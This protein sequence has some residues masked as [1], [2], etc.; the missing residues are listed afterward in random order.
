[1][2]Q[3]I[4]DRLREERSGIEQYVDQTLKGVENRDLS[5]TEVKAVN[6]AKA[7]IQQIDAQAKPLIEY[8]ESRSAAA[9][10]T[11]LVSKATG[12]RAHDVELRS[13]GEQ[14]VASDVFT[15]YNGRGT[16]SRL[17]IETRALPLS[18]TSMAAALPVSPRYDLTA[19]PPPSPLLDLID[20]IPIS[21]NSVEFI[22]WAKI[23]GGADIVA[24][25]AVKP[26]V[27]WAPTV[28]S[29]TLVTIAAWTSATRQLLEDSSAIRAMI[30]TGLRREITQ[31]EESEAAAALV[32]APLP[33]VTGPSM[34]ESIR[35]GVGT[36][37]AQGYRPNAVLLNPA[38]WA[39]LDIEIWLG[40]GGGSAGAPSS[41]NG[42]W[43]LSPVASNVQPVG[44]ATV[45][46]YS[47]GAQRFVRSGTSIFVTDSHGEL[48][49][50]NTFVVLAESRQLT[51]VTRPA[52]FAECTVVAVP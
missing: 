38:D 32:A 10:F 26:S 27:E 13:M 33:A 24:E 20:S 17:Q 47:A 41:K 28:S 52:A 51:V 23:A 39:S 29:Q 7:R 11:R 45:G 8:M 4:L 37:Q 40:G 50:A 48:F 3:A 16:S 1:M 6:D 36:V 12:Q 15:T 35:V 22:V 25:G 42:F 49:T 44:T 5:D 34:L 30:D 43:G 21:Q 19:P 2:S 9:D 46:D 18:L 14:F 31:K